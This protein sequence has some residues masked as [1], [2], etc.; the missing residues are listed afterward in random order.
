MILCNDYVGSHCPA[1]QRNW[2][3]P[4]IRR[5]LI[6]ESHGSLRGWTAAD[7]HGDARTAA[8]DPRARIG[9]RHGAAGRAARHRVHR[10][11]AR[12][13]SQRGHRHQN[14]KETSNEFGDLPHP[15]DS[16]IASTALRRL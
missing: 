13:Y 3:N 14:Y 11:S 2:L 10:L 12:H 8:G 7:R 1:V 5:P 16:M 9:G 4:V 15:R 6:D